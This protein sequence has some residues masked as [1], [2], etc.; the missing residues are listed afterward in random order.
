[1]FCLST[2]S[3][4]M[5]AFMKKIV[6]L[7]IV[8]FGIAVMFAF[9]LQYIIP[10]LYLITGFIF[11]TF[12]FFWAKAKELDEQYDGWYYVLNTGKGMMYF[13]ISGSLLWVP[14]LLPFL[15]QQRQKFAF[16]KREGQEEKLP[17][18]F[19]FLRNPVKWHREWF[20][21]FYQ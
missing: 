16:R 9:H 3:K 12:F 6:K 13:L 14:V 4:G 17:S 10:L 15:I 1:V 20:D 11:Y 7:L 8:G 2:I 19:Q 5:V 18:W 21:N